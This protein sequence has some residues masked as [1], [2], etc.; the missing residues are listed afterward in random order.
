ML[1]NGEGVSPAGAVARNGAE[2]S[3]GEGRDPIQ[4]TERVETLVAPSPDESRLIHVEA[5][6]SCHEGEKVAD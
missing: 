6:Q 5:R 4:L 2:D 1:P 3:S